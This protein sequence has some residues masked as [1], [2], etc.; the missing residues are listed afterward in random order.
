[1]AISLQKGQKIDLTKGRAGLSSIT[2]GLGWDPVKKSGGFFGFGGGSSNIDCDAS[3]LMLNENGKLADKKDLVYFGNKTSSCGSVQHSG[4]NLTGEGEG[5][6][7][8]IRV[9]LGRI[10]AHIHRL[11]FVVNIYQGVQRKQDFGMIQNAFIRVLDNSNSSELVHFNL[12]DNFSG[13][14][15]LVP[16]EIYRHNGEWKFNAVGDGTKDASISEIANRY[17]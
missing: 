13:L 1:M 17:V 11:V 15:A 9:D 16:G 12:T 5:D 6:D 10:P 14:M 3:V 8:Q 2:V 7:E 4:D